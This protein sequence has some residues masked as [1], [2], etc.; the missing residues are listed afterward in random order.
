MSRINLISH[1]QQDVLPHNTFPSRLEV[2]TFLQRHG[3]S[4][5]KTFLRSL[6]YH[7]SPYIVGLALESDYAQAVTAVGLSFGQKCISIDIDKRSALDTKDPFL[8]VFF[9]G[10]ASVSSKQGDEYPNTFILV[11]FGMAQMVLLVK[12]HFGCHTRGIDLGTLLAPNAV[13]PWSPARVISARVLGSSGL[14]LQELKC[15]EDMAAEAHQLDQLKPRSMQG[16]ISGLTMR[17][18]GKWDLQNDRYKT[19]VRRSTRQTVVITTTS[20]KEVATRAVGMKGRQTTLSATQVRVNEVAAVRVEGRQELANSERA[21]EFLLL[22]VLQGIKSFQKSPFIRLFWF[23]TWKAFRPPDVSITL[24]PTHVES[25][26]RSARLNESQEMVVKTID[27]TERSIIVHGPPGTGKT[28]TIAAIAR[29]WDL[30][31]CPVWIIAHSNVAVKNIANSLYRRGVDFKIIV[32]K[33]FYEGWHEHLYEAVE[34]KLIRTDELPTDQVATERII[35]DSCIILSTLGTLSNPALDQNGMFKIVPVERLI[36]DEASQIRIFEFLVSC[37]ARFISLVTPISVSQFDL[38]Q[39]FYAFDPSFCLVPPFNH[40]EVPT[41][42]TVFDLPHLNT[43][44]RRWLLNTQYRM[45]VNLGNFISEAIYQRKLISAHPDTSTDCVRFVDVRGGEGK[46]G[47]SS[48][49]SLFSS[50]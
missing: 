7:S 19:R 2:Q 45:P 17:K 48:I 35:G 14:V 39:P 31:D 20:G 43:S 21:A 41:M 28:T 46:L 29:I 1:V 32:S 3:G 15:L 5:L 25:V 9:A 27:S 10:K 22:S 33:D 50:Y 47:N 42:Q 16:E 44:L 4:S 8:Q 23:P 6:P 13:A 49:V 24:S 11:G 26:L 30:H 36:V 12:K 38:L 37:P 34:E 18:D 40:D